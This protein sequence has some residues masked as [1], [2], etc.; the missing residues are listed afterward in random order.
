MPAAEKSFSSLITC[1]QFNQDKKLLAWIQDI[2]WLPTSLLSSSTVRAELSIFVLSFPQASKPSYLRFIDKKFVIE[3]ISFFCFGKEERLGNRRTPSRIDPQH[4]QEVEE[5]VHRRS[6]AAKFSSINNENSL[7]S[8][9]EGA[10][11]AE[12]MKHN[13]ILIM[14]DFQLETKEHIDSAKKSRNAACL[15]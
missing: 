8:T 12:L 9:Q 10:F 15:Y 2:G 1:S 6:A 11:F 3:T 13:Y 14:E 7:E 5:F 4:R